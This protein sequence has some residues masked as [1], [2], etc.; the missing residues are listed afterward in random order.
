MVRRTES[1]IDTADGQNA[2]VKHVLRKWKR[3][4]GESTIALLSNTIEGS[5]GRES[6]HVKNARVVKRWRKIKEALGQ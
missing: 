5:G 4:R 1:K 2:R 3:F 6:A